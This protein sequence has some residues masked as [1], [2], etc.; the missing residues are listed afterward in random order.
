MA[1]VKNGQNGTGRGRD[2]TCAPVM[3]EGSRDRT[4]HLCNA[5]DGHQSVQEEHRH[6]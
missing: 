1:P 4:P 2:R 3:S 6:M 5:V